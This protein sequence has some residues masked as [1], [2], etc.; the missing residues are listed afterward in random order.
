MRFRLVLK[1]T[2][3]NNLE[4]LMSVFVSFHRQRFVNSTCAI[5]AIGWAS[6]IL[7]HRSL[8][9]IANSLH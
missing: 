8:R 5:S 6:Y 2:T 7:L 1:S 4:R 3:L 9:P